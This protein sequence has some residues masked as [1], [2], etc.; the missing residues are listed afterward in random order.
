MNEK[1]FSGVPSGRVSR[2]VPRHRQVCWM[3]FGGPGGVYLLN[4]VS[5]SCYFYK[6]D[7]NIGIEVRYD[8]EV[9]GSTT[10]ML[11]SR[12]IGPP[13]SESIGKITFDVDGPGG[14]Y[15]SAVAVDRVH[16]LVKVRE[17]VLC[18]PVLF[19]KAYSDTGPDQ[20]WAVNVVRTRIEPWRCQI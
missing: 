20:P 10:R 5:I 17:P 18:L 9:E 3:H 16:A 13:G 8:R 1:Q 2:G 7:W 4:V 14:E 6:S 15:I 11:G 19:H 12:T